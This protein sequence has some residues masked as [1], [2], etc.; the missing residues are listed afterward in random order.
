M[1]KN[2]GVFALLLP[3]AMAVA[4]TA[5]A[6][7]VAAAKCSAATLQGTYL[8]SYTGSVVSEK[9]RGPFAYAGHEVYDGRGHVSGVS[10]SSTNGKIVRRARSTGTYKVFADCS[11]TLTYTDGSTYDL[12][13]APDGSSNMFVQ[14]NPG[15]LAAGSEHRVAGG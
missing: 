13:V 3:L 7:E 2:L 9:D 8:Y 14:T 5:N 6:A 11:G 4:G 15:S 12:F 1:R 10:T